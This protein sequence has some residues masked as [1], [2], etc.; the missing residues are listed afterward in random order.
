MKGEETGGRGE[1]GG[2][3]G[4]EGGVDV[5][6]E[7][8][9]EVMLF[10]AK[11]DFCSSVSV[12]LTLSLP[13]PLSLSLRSPPPPPPSPIPSLCMC[14][15]LCFIRTRSLPVH[16]YIIFALACFSH[17]TDQVKNDHRQI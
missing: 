5:N 7:D 12:K 9:Y 16:A 6:C 13:P 10:L 14:K 2:R 1:R 17:K 8:I 4:L 3:Q 15:Q 11:V